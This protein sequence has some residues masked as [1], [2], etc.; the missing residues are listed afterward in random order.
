MSHDSKGVT[1]KFFINKSAEED[2]MVEEKYILTLTVT[3]DQ[4]K[5]IEGFLKERKWQNIITGMYN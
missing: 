1:T 4:R 3:N 2:K 5:E